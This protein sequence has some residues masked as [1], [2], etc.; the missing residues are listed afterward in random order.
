MSGEKGMNKRQ[1]KKQLKN[2]GGNIPIDCFL[3]IQ[4]S[5]YSAPAY[6]NPKQ[7]YIATID[8]AEGE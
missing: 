7:L 3:H 5:L 6:I 4:S 8:L 2:Q 1:Y